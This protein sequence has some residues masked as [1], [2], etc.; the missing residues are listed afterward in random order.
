MFCS[1]GV[2]TVNV[3]LVWREPAGRL[4]C[5]TV[6]VPENRRKLIGGKQA[7]V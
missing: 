3:T 4:H 7:E 6:R 5:A 2:P 1:S